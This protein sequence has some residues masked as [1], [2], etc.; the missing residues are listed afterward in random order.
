[1]PFVLTFT[2]LSNYQIYHPSFIQ[3]S[4]PIRARV[5]A[6]IRFTLGE[7][8]TCLTVYKKGRAT[9]VFQSPKCPRWK[10]YDY[11]SQSKTMAHCQ[12]AM[13]QGRRK[14]REDRTLCVLDIRI[15][16]PGSSIISFH[17][18]W[19]IIDF[20]SGIDEL[21]RSTYMVLRDL[22]EQTY[23]YAPPGC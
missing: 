19:R 22:L 21:H 3:T 2:F 13:L 4:T 12:S 5:S 7:S 11:D 17:F 6:T 18:L 14:S 20:G 16:F 10:L 23:E 8:S 1:M 15:P 9:E